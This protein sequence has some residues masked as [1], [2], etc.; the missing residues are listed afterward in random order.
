ML[1]VAKWIV[2]S[3]PFDRLYYYG[4][5]RPVHVSFGPDQSRMAI[6]LIVNASG[7]RLPRPLKFE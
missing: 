3:L 2:Q 4:K 6:Q 1:E 5:D 7:A